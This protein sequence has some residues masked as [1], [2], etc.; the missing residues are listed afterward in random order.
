MSSSPTSAALR[1]AWN[2]LLSSVLLLLTPNEVEYIVIA[3]AAVFWRRDELRRERSSSTSATTITQ[4]T[5]PTTT[6]AAMIT[7]VE[8]PPRPPLCAD[9][10]ELTDVVDVEPFDVE[11][12]VPP[13]GDDDDRV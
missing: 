10:V 12:F 6:I 4:T 7:G 11:P 8:S 2:P 1:D 13:V 3:A 9:A 5:S